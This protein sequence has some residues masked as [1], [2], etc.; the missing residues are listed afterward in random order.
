MD[1]DDDDD[2]RP[3]KRRRSDGPET[4]AGLLGVLPCDLFPSIVCHVQPEDA[5][6][7]FRTCR[8]VRAQRNTATM[9]T[10]LLR[11]AY[12]DAFGSALGRAQFDRDRLMLYGRKDARCTSA[13]Q[14]ATDV[15][16]RVVFVSTHEAST[17]L[18]CCS[19]VLQLGPFARLRSAVRVRFVGFNVQLFV[20]Y[21][22]SYAASR[23]TAM[24]LHPRRYDH[25]TWMHNVAAVMLLVAKGERALCTWPQL[26]DRSDEMNE[27]IATVI[28][29]S[30]R[31]ESWVALRVGEFIEWM[32]DRER[33]Q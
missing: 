6:A 16:A 4:A 7:L 29:S 18:M 13:Q 5:R 9:R 24:M 32:N 11:M 2:E 25:V 20:D 31:H 27:V 1:D 19:P 8:F 28:R 21:C 3:S 23:N 30:V 22:T 12:D 17:G 33:F 14:H 15:L 10:V 26:A